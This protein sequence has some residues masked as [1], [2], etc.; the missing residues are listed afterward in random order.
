MPLR[1]EPVFDEK[2]TSVRK[3]EPKTKGLDPLRIIIRSFGVSKNSKTRRSRLPL[4]EYDFTAHHRKMSSCEVPV[5]K[6][7]DC[8]VGFRAASPVLCIRGLSVTLREVFTVRSRPGC[9]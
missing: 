7:P 5:E 1:R 2:E 6:K 4:H 3:A 8:R 9:L